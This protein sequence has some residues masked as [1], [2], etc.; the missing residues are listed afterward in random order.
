MAV[1]KK[2]ISVSRKKVRLNSNPLK[3]KINFECKN[4]NEF[5]LPHRVCIIK[6]NNTNLIKKYKKNF[7]FSTLLKVND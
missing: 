3:T 7:S 1:P 5:K 2:K 6:N 4:S